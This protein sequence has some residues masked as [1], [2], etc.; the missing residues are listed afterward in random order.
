MGEEAPIYDEYII[1]QF[2]IPKTFSKTL[3]LLP[4]RDLSNGMWYATYT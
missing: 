2:H 4:R 3:G 1:I